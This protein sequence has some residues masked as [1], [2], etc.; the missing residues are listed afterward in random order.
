MCKEEVNHHPHAYLMS[1]IQPLRLECEQLEDQDETQHDTP[2]KNNEKNFE[3][4]IETTATPLEELAALLNTSGEEILPPSHLGP[5]GS[6]IVMGVRYFLRGLQGDAFQTLMKCKE[7]DFVREDG[8]PHGGS[9]KG[10]RRRKH[11]QGAEWVWM[12]RKGMIFHLKIYN[13]GQQEAWLRWL[14][15]KEFGHHLEYPFSRR[16]GVEERW[17][18]VCIFGQQRARINGANME[19]ISHGTFIT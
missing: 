6:N 9:T 2:M 7:R 3:P 18:D 17:Q 10:G 11:P 13:T 4:K 5:H 1:Y 15:L 8:S 19:Y 12:R 16:M 14:L